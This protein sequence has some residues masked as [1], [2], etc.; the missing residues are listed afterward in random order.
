MNLLEDSLWIFGDSFC[1]DDTPRWAGFL[2]EFLKKKY[3][4][5]QS[6]IK[7]YNYAMGSCDT[8]TILDIWLQMIPNIKENDAVVVCLSDT[9]RC[10]Y[11][12]KKEHHYTL[13]SWGDKRKY[14]VEMCW[15]FAPKGLDYSVHIDK[16][17]TW[18]IFWNYDELEF[19]KF[20]EKFLL[21]HDTD[22]QKETMCKL[23]KV[24]YDL[25]PTKKKFVYNWVDWKST[26]T[27]ISFIHD[28]TWLT[29]NIF[30]GYWETLDL[31]YKRYWGSKGIKNDQHLSS[32]CEVLLFNHIKEIFNL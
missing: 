10:R 6:D 25:T 29:K 8:R 22:A 3:P 23:A 12:I 26:S 17:N 5:N 7:Y 20:Q 1:T 18:D 4:F 32:Q 9:S 28:K 24:I 19:S 15:D 14:P 31:E 30:Q 11:P 16:I 21:M 2:R 13:P 27:D